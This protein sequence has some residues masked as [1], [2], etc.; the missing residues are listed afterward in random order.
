MCAYSPSYNILHPHVQKWIWKR[1]WESLNVIQENSIP[2]ILEHKNDVII[3]AATAGGKTEAAFFPII[4]FLLSNQASGFRVL[5]VSPLR[6]LINDQC[7]RLS[8]IV[9]GTDID[10]TPWHGD[11]SSSTKRASIKNPSGILII[12]PESLESLLMNKRH[13]IHSL[14]NSLDYIVIDELH[15]YLGT[16]RGM[17]LRSLISRI[18]KIIK[19]NPPRVAMSATLSDYSAAANFLRNNGESYSVPYPGDNAQDIKI[20]LKFYNSETIKLDYDIV[21]E[22][23]SKLRGSNNLVFTN[24]RSTAELYTVELSEL[25][26]KRNV[27]NEFRA[28]HGNLS[29]VEREQVEKELYLGNLPITAFCT[30]TLELGVDIGSVKSIAQ[31]GAI[32]SVSSLRQRLGRSGRRN[33]PSMLRIFSQKSDTPIFKD[34]NFNL[35]QNIAV[36]ELL[37]EK[38]Y[39]LPETN[40]FHFS[41]LIQQILS[42]LSSYGSFYPKEGWELLCNNGTFS[43]INSKMYLDLLTSLGEHEI[44]SQIGNGQ[45]ITGKRGEWLTRQ[46]D[47]YAAFN[48][49]KDIEVYNIGSSKQIGTLQFMPD[50]DFVIILAGRRWIAKEVDKHNNRVY[51]AP[52]ESGGEAFFLGESPDVNIL[53][54][55]KM[56]DIYT[57]NTMY[58]Y[59][60]LNTGADKQLI[61]ARESFLNYKLDKESYIEFSIT[62][63]LMTWA[64][65]RINR[66]ISLLYQ[67]FYGVEIPYN[68]IYL[69]NMNIDNI[70]K[71]LSL[72]IPMAQD[73]AHLL[74]R[75]QKER[76]KYDIYLPDSLLNLE[77]ANT[78][79]DLTGGLSLLREIVYCL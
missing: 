27:P 1:G 65:D 24:S 48:A 72:S 34:L 58:K 66:T 49:S 64:G 8:D 15:Y 18:V 21:Q 3:S 38:R 9:D 22:I 67:Y 71:I 32:T 39:E 50:I 7:R 57:S 61:K 11:I 44:I 10:I 69:C 62:T 54:T 43:N 29:M 25:S 51:V 75:K 78:Y 6:A 26:K 35:I 30:S 2:V 47:F 4:S 5:Y 14:F 56:K 20:L 19:R 12:T 33:E 17:Q 59:L 13:L 31:I 63:T 36:T 16:E 45:I 70:K 23:F 40:R 60:D 46:L 73:L 55:R 42:V 79:L 28:H 74:P 52:V 68:H 37:L 77:Y 76:E 41:T 53:I